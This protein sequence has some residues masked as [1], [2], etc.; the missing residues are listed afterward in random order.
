MISH[1]LGSL[2]RFGN[3]RG[4]YTYDCLVLHHTE[5]QHTKGLG[6]F[7]WVH[8]SPKA[9]ARYMCPGLRLK[10]TSA[11]QPACFADLSRMCSDLNSSTC[12]HTMNTASTSSRCLIMEIGLGHG[13]IPI[14]SSIIHQPHIYVS[15]CLLYQ[16]RKSE[17]QQGAQSCPQA[18]VVQH[19]IS[20]RAGIQPI[21]MPKNKV[22]SLFGP[23]L[24]DQRAHIIVVAYFAWLE[25]DRL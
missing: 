12:A 17:S 23:S 14:Y 19:V 5:R 24:V 22:L 6:F 13:A 1:P 18:A 16:G 8:F 2:P 3:V 25:P 15:T 11:P 20:C 7:S 10:T 21:C 4:H 9:A